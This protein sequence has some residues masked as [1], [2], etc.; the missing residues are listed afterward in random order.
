MT[1]KQE[2]ILKAALELFANEGYAAT[3]TSKI[4]KKAGVSEGLI[5]RH[6]ANKQA[7]LHALV[8]K[9]EEKIGEIFGPVLFESDPKTVIRRTIEI[10]FEI[11]ESEYN[12]WKL[13]FILKWQKEYNNPDKMKPL[14]EKLAVSF[15]E[16]GYEDPEKEAELFNLILEGIAND[17]LKGNQDKSSGMKEFLLKKYKV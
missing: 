12:F 3:P 7:L 5:F 14:L 16:L 6:F 17:I 4:A 15:K 1:D 2:K 8:Q 9:A 10:P 13:Q 11:S